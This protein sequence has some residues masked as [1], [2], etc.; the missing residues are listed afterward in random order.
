METT[1]MRRFLHD[2]ANSLNAAKINTY[3]LGRLHGETIDKESFA[4]LNSALQSAE[5]LVADFHRRVH[6]ETPRVEAHSA[7][8]QG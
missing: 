1:D 4:G 2:L 6:E 3:L 8:A 5:R 7:G